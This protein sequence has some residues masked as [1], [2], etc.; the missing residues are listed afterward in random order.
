M[1][2]LN[3]E[4]PVRDGYSNPTLTVQESKEKPNDSF[5][6]LGDQHEFY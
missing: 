5:N 4:K 6:Y 2:M 3:D 1:S